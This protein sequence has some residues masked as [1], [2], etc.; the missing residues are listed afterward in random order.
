MVAAVLADVELVNVINPLELHDRNTN[1]EFGEAV[2]EREPESSQ[3]LVPMGVVEP[4]LEGETA[5]VI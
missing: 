4:V 3:T 5:N 2:I 1:P